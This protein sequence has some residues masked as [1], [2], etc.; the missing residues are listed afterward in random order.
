M[1]GNSIP[2]SP[3]S[4]VI[5]LSS[6][7]AMS[8]CAESIIIPAIPNIIQSY[9]LELNDSAWIIGAFII[10]GAI[11]TPVSSQL[12]DIFGKKNTLTVLIILFSIGNII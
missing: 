10:S 8:I 7:S 1:F 12:S 11:M 2:L 6:I 5:I 9:N 3:W 4:S